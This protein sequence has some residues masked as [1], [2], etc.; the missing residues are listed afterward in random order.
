[1]EVPVGSGGDGNW[2]GLKM[3]FPFLHGAEVSALHGT[4]RQLQPFLRTPQLQHSL[5]ME[6]RVSPGPGTPRPPP[7]GTWES[8]LDKPSS[9]SKS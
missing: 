9:P 3:I 8:S 6:P 5:E 1:M 4:S 2:R 7:P